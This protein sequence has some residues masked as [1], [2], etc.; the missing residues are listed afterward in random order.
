MEK[1]SLVL[2]APQ[3]KQLL[4][5]FFVRECSM[6]NHGQKEYSRQ[7]IFQKMCSLR[8]QYENLQFCT[9][10][11]PVLRQFRNDSCQEIST[12]EINPNGGLNFSNP[13]FLYESKCTNI[14][15]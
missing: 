2:S 9:L 13:S 3:Q 12:M 6:N 11:L 4:Y 14:V 15:S 1:I 10:K 7:H 8:S 5:D